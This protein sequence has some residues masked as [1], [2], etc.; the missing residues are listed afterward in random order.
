M[1]TKELDLWKGEFGDQYRDRNVITDEHM[2][3]RISAWS[4]N[5]NAIS[6]F[7]S[8][9]GLPK[10]Y[11]EV[12]CG[13]GINLLAIEKIYRANNEMAIPYACEP[14]AQTRNLANNACRKQN[15]F[16]V[17]LPDD[18]NATDL[19][20]ESHA[21]ELAFTSGVLI[22]IHPD[23]QLKAMEELY[24]VSQRYII[25]M[26]YFSPDLREIN[27]HEQKAL[28][29]RDYGSMWL[30][31]FNLRCLGCYFAWKRMSNLDNIT[32][33]IFEKVN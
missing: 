32:T 16:P 3:A 18:A 9:K 11:L 13:A 14:N 30:D 8:I 7:G 20:F 10:S 28:W 27:Y 25:S 15:L 19:K 12:G 33:W 21:V 26:E 4:N 6:M 22:H 24:R 1:S 29:T 17:W 31:N 5:F 23:N 2:N